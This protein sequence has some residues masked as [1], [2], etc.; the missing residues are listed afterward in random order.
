M[1]SIVMLVHDVT[2]LTVTLFKLTVDI[3][4]IAV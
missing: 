1:G 3:T 4:H 2:D